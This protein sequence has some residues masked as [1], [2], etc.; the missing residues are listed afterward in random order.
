MEP[1]RIF[2]EVNKAMFHLHEAEHLARM[3]GRHTLQRNILRA[4]EQVQLA[5]YQPPEPPEKPRVIY[6]G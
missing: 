2:V 5:V 1:D 3:T 6:N 4:I